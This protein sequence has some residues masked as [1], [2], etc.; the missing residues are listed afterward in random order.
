MNGDRAARFGGARR[1]V[2]K[3][4]S[5]VLRDGD[6]FDRVTFTSLV[7]DLV[8]LVRDGVEVICVCSGAVALGLAQLGGQPRPEKLSALQA[9]AAIGQGTL[10]RLWN[11]E[12]SHY[13]MVAGQVLLTHDDLRHRG[14]FLAARHTL[15]ALL[16]LGAV[17]IINEND[18][19]AVEEI[20]LGDNDMLSSQI[21][22]LVG[23]DLLVILSDVDGLYDRDPRHPDARLHHHVPR[24][25]GLV[26]GSAGGSQSGL[27][28]GGMQTKVQAVQQVNRLG[29]PGVIAGGKRP[30]VLRRLYDGEL[31]G[32]WF[33]PEGDS[34]GS[35]KHWIAYAP[36]AQGRLVV[37][38]GAVRAISAAGR[39]LLPVG[40]RAVTGDFLVGDV[41][42][43][44][45][46]QGHVFA[47]GLV[48]HSAE[49]LRAVAGG[50]LG[51]EQPE[52]VHRNDLVLL[53]P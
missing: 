4:G 7:K 6:S 20:K 13:G 39:S 21:V 32:S 19:V 10:M 47:R 29:V 45:D 18:T 2:V 34:M 16:D 8:G 43:I 48:S 5:A 25:D 53:A 33:D 1:V 37:D 22:S 12:L 36:K 51:A 24:I 41:V 30:R 40:L 17:P 38:T 3:I 42:E 49:T 14:R 9:V 28:S 52:A 11:G 46:E 15:N 50:H 26:L 27:G 44:A 35:R 31:L 23:A